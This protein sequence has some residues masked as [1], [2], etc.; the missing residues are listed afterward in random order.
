[1]FLNKKLAI[2]GTGLIGGSLCLALQKQGAFREI[3]LYD[4]NAATR[5][6]LNIKHGLQETV[7]DADIILLA[8]PLETFPA[9]LPTIM[10]HL[11]EQAIISDM[12]SVKLP[13]VEATLPYRGHHFFVPAHPI[14]GSE[15]TGFEAA[16]ADLFRDKQ[17]ILC[18]EEKDVQSEAVAT[19]KAIWE[20]AGAKIVYM[21]YPL[22][23]IVYAYVSHLPQ[24]IAFA[25]TPDRLLLQDAKYTTFLRLTHSSPALWVEIF[26]ANR[27]NIVN[28]TE[29]YLGFISHITQELLE[30]PSEATPASVSDASPLGA[31][32]IANCLVATMLS[33]EPEF[34]FNVTEFAG[35][36]FRDMTSLAKENIETLL[37]AISGNH[38]AVSQVLQ[39]FSQRLLLLKQGIA[40]NDKATLL[41]LLTQ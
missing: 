3:A 19:I 23:D 21:P 13:F 22:H 25:L 29:N 36:G 30:T 14:A 12:A 6:A 20:L 17:V 37:E 11:K 18:P 34:G 27:E 9:L 7:E 2:I 39:A 24:L 32:V 41:T 16:N 4:S 35:S 38:L 33:L 31:N 8:T 26:L 5:H 40:A 10:P 28:A 15:K 1:M